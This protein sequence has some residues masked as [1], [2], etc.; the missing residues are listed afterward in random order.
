MSDSFPLSAPDAVADCQKLF[1]FDPGF[2]V[3]MFSTPD[4]HTP[5]MDPDYVFDPATTRSILAGF[6]YNR[7]VMV[8]GYHGTGKSTH[9]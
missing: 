8:Q 2:D 5:I 3:A 9:I 1:G 4:E 6:A 7:R